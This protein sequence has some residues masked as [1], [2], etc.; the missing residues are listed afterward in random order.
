[1]ERKLFLSFALFDTT[2]PPKEISKRTSIT[3]YTELL[4]GERRPELVLPR[5]NLWSIRSSVQS[6]EVSEH[7]DS[8]ATILEPAQTE[9]RDIAKTGLAR[10]TIVIYHDKRIPPITIPPSMARFAGFIN[11][12]IDI[13]HFF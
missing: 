9:L 10:L 3:P 4:K 8:L 5:T 6:D 1:M 2:I 13:D 12:E 7:W 11:A